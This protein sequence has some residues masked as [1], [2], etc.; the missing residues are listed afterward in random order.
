MK[1]PHSLNEFIGSHLQDTLKQLERTR[2]RMRSTWWL[3]VLCLGLA[4]L[5]YLFVVEPIH[6]EQSK[7][8]E[9]Y[10]KLAYIGIGIVLAL[11]GVML[12]RNLMM[13]QFVDRPSEHLQREYKQKVIAPLL[14]FVHPHYIY[15]PTENLPVEDFVETGLFANKDYT[16][17]GNDLITGRMGYLLFQFCDLRVSVIPGARFQRAKADTVFYGSCYMLQSPRYFGTPVYVHSR[18]CKFMEMVN[19]GNFLMLSDKAFNQ[20]FVVYSADVAEAEQLLKP[21]LLKRIS[22]LQF[23]PDISLFIAFHK[24]RIYIAVNTGMDN[25]E[26]N[27]NR[28]LEDRQLLIDYCMVFMHQLQLVQEMRDSISIWTT[29]AFSRS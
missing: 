3:W 19:P 18:G 26:L 27:M 13:R 11:A 14:Q 24:H 16:V 7:G 12:I 4:A 2:R 20:R 17:Q 5:F 28:S 8:H 23:M 9:L 10:I 6:L 29:A 22:A 1:S 15:E 25:F 21:S